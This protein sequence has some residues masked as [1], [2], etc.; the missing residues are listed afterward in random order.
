MWKSKL[1]ESTIEKKKATPSG[2]NFKIKKCAEV[3]DNLFANV[4]NNGPVD[5]EFSYGEA[6]YKIGLTNLQAYLFGLM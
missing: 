5:V 6:K 4:E 2:F 1:K 3:A